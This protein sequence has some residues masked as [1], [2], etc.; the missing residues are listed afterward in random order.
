MSKGE[1]QLVINRSLYLLKK[2]N[3]EEELTLEEE[4][5]L[6]NNLYYR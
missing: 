3:Q 1:T 4:L 5:I 2:V 6:V